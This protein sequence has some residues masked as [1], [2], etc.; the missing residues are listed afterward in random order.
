MS[1]YHDISIDDL[2]DNSCKLNV[3]FAHTLSPCVLPA[4]NYWDCKKHLKPSLTAQH[5]RIL[6]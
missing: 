5:Q 1:D 2:L 3:K 6:Y 4:F